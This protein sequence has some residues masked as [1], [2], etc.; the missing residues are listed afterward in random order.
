[1]DLFWQFYYDYICCCLLPK[2]DSVDNI[3]DIDNDI[4]N[5]STNNLDYN[6]NP[7]KIYYY[8]SNSS[9]SLSEDTKEYIIKG[10]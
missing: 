1:M 7:D 9:S 5:T 3:N 6:P 2:N 10:Q 4:N 8:T